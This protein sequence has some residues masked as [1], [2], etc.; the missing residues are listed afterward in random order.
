MVLGM[1]LVVAQTDDEVMLTGRRTW[2]WG[3][4]SGSSRG[5]GEEQG[6]DDMARRLLLL[7]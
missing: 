5:G 3:S 4:G 1:V 7:G 6:E 2:G